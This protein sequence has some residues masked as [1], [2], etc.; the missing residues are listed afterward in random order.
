MAELKCPHCGQA[1]TVD[2][3]ELSSIVQQIRDKEFEKDLNMRTSELQKHLEE[4]HALEISAKETEITLRT[5]EQY[6]KELEE[7]AKELGDL[8]EKQAQDIEAL[9]EELRKAQINKNNEADIAKLN[10]RISELEKQINEAAAYTINRFPMLMDYY[11]KLKEEDKEGA[12]E[13]STNIVTEADQIFIRNIQK[14]IATL[15]KTQ[16][17]MMKLQ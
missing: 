8:K 6:E 12:K 1:F 15:Q 17:F 10:S 4:K 2:D 7:R 5:K 16:A 14:L 11:I 3:T 9:R 13:T